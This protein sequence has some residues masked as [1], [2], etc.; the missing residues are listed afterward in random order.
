M[1][2]KCVRFSNSGLR[3][4]LPVCCTVFS[5][6]AASLVVTGGTT[7]GSYNFAGKASPSWTN[8]GLVA[9]ESETSAEP[10]VH[11]FNAAGQEVRTI[12][13]TIPEA[14]VVGVR[15]SSAGNDGTVT[16]CGWTQNAEGHLGQFVA[17]APPD[18]SSPIT[19]VRTDPY[20]PHAITMSPDGTI[21]TKGIYYNP[22]KSALDKQATGGVIRHFDHT[23]KPIAAFIPQPA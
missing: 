11:L 14:R 20:A 10:V 12:Y 3:V 19:V 22:S 8:G 1:C 6:S 9:L 23:G 4:L 2:N 13:F 5:A 17:I 16:L 7:I 21:W 18:A 15:G